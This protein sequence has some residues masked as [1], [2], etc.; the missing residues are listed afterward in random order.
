MSDGTLFNIGIKSSGGSYR[1]LIIITDTIQ[2]ALS[3]AKSKV[4]YNETVVQVDASSTDVY[5][6]YSV[7]KGKA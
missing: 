2:A 6:D 4:A 3:I 5:I 1:T 7:C